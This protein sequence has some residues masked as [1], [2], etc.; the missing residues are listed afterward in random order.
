MS[1]QRTTAASNWVVIMEYRVQGPEQQRQLV[2][3]LA[4]IVELS[5]HG[6]E[7]FLDARFHTSTDGHRVIN[8]MNWATEADFRRF[9]ATSDRTAR[10]AAVQRVLDS[11]PGGVDAPAFGGPPPTYTVARTVT[12]SLQP[13]SD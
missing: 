11:I 9:G 1:E 4:S 6:A 8:V 12:P 2:D 13:A 7:G 5:L 10:D 3:G